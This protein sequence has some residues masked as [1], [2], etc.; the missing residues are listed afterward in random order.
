MHFDAPIDDEVH[1]VAL[2]ALLKDGLRWGALQL[3]GDLGDVRQVFTGNGLEKINALEEQ[4][5]FNRA[6]QASTTLLKSCHRKKDAIAPKE[7]STIP[8]AR[9]QG[10][11]TGPHGAIN[12]DTEAQVGAQHK[13]PSALAQELVALAEKYAVLLILRQEREALVAC[14][15]RR[16][17]GAAGAARRTTARHLAQRFP[18]ALRELETL[19]AL[20][21]A[22]R[23]DTVQRELTVALAQPGRRVPRRRWVRLVLAY[24][25]GLRE[26]LA[27]RRWLRAHAPR[28]GAIAPTL[29]ERFRSWYERGGHG[30]R[31]R[32][33]IDARWLH[34]YLAP[35]E[36]RL[37]ELVWRELATEHGLTPLA[38]RDLVLGRVGRV[39]RQGSEHE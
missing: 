6:D 23:C 17:D 9:R 28:R 19:D 27:I 21:V 20:A 36:G 29:V 4:D 5:L 14:G 15:I 11:W 34:R 13:D 24:H 30:A 33:Q 2:V 38:V 16:L 7:R 25:R 26:G 1:R 32:H 3:V 35:P 18:G 22:G 10:K 12:L 8:E 31:P 39:G 37:S